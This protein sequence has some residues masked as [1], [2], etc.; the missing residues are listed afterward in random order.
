MPSS[1]AMIAG[2]SRYTS[3]SKRMSSFAHL[4]SHPGNAELSLEEWMR[5]IVR[6]RKMTKALSKTHLVWMISRLLS[7]TSHLILTPLTFSSLAGLENGATTSLP[8]FLIFPLTSIS[9]RVMTYFCE[10]TPR[11]YIQVE[12]T[13]MQWHY[14]DAEPVFAKRQAL[15]LMSHLTGGPL[16]NTATEVLDSASIIQV[17]PLAVSKGRA[18]HH[19]LTFLQ[20]HSQTSRGAVGAAAAAPVGAL[21]ER[22]EERRVW[23]DGFHT[24]VKFLAS[25]LTA[26]D[27]EERCIPSRALGRVIGVGADEGRSALATHHNL[28]IFTP[29][30]SSMV[31]HS[32][33][34]TV[35]LE[36]VEGDA[37]AQRPSDGLVGLSRCRIA[38]T[39]AARAS[40]NA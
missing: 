39:Y 14:A 23:A 25:N 19:L 36:Q 18:L 7:S 28:A 31:S 29:S 4:P 3:H 10:R 12:E 8:P 1:P 2:P 21:E 6:Q 27:T 34:P 9:L 30:S 16:S 40:S 17:R 24:D 33:V 11:S 22:G 32:S 37:R 13:L 38:S 15:D 20:R 35:S 5:W 26:Q